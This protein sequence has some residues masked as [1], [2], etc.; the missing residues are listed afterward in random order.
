MAPS[1]WA[2]A[3][4]LDDPNLAESAAESAVKAQSEL[5][6]YI[7]QYVEART[8]EERQFVAALT[9]LYFPGL[10]PFVEGSYPRYK[11]FRKIDN[12]RDNWWCQDVGSLEDEDSSSRLL[13]VPRGN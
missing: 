3:A 8:P 2:R 4:L 13:M 11:A 5:K 1:A 10:R 9:V 12:Y 6:P 7:Q